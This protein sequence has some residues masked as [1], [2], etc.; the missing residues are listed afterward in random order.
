MDESC[1]REAPAVAHTPTPP[2]SHTVF[3]GTAGWTLPPAAR[4]RFPPGASVLERYAGL[5]N[6]VEVNSTFKTTPR[7]ATCARW[8]ATVPPAFR[9]SLKLPREITHT[10]RL[11]AARAPLAA[12]LEVAAALG[13]RRGPLL[14][15]LPPSLA[16]EATL[17]ETFLGDLRA[18]TPGPDA[19]EPRHPS[20]FAPEPTALLA[21]FRMARVAADPPRA[22]GDGLPAGEP[23]LAYFRLHGSPRVYYSG[24]DGEA[25]DA[26]AARVADAG[27]RARE[28]WCIFDNTAAGEATADALALRQRLGVV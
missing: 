25:L 1:D 13:D 6:A 14:V 4:E 22:P 5:L 12:F 15:Q 18:L 11:R 26:W 2:H 27:A 21:R 24:Y 9:F 10:H 17:V 23:A 7:A 8:A 16:F 3:L 20:W 19:L 28:V